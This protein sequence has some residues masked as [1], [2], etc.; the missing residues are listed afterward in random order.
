V[1]V[2]VPVLLDNTSLQTVTDYRV[3]GAVTWRF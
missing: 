1:G 2:D 3:R